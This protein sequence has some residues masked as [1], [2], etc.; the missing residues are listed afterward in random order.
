[1]FGFFKNSSKDQQVRQ[2]NHV[3]ELQA[4]DL[5]TFKPRTILPQE[6]QGETVTVSKVYAYQYSEGLVAEFALSLKSGETLT[7]TLDENEEFLCLSKTIARET[8]GQLFN[9]DEFA[10]LF[11][12][13]YA[14]ITT[15]HSNTTTELKEW[16]A[17]EYHQTIKEAPAYF[18][19][20]DRRTKGVSA[21]QDDASEELRY[22]ECEGVP[23]EYSLYI[24][25]WEDGS[26]DVFIQK[27]VPLNVIE[28]MWPNG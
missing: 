18:Y 8:V 27:S 19:N 26:T 24:E 23:S 16:L 1:M 28:E 21:Y 14:T 7:C 9:L 5:I 22:Y 17:D 2:L 4:G 3:R 20:E 12:E 11:G 6:L 10:L 25:V 15:L 13:E